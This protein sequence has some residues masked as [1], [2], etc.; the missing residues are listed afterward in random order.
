MRKVWVLVLRSEK[1]Q[2]Q[3]SKAPGKVSF[4][5]SGKDQQCGDP[6]VQ[7]EHTWTPPLIPLV[8]IKFAVHTAPC[9]LFAMQGASK[10]P[11]RFLGTCLGGSGQRQQCMP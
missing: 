6:A 11:G 9:T 4:Q 2:R 5:S 10:A 8:G 3:P 1:L 7:L